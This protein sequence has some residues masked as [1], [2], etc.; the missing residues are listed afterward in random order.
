MRE[1]YRDGGAAGGGIIRRRRGLFAKGVPALKDIEDDRGALAS[2]CC[3]RVCRGTCATL[4]VALYDAY[5]RRARR[6]RVTC[7]GSAMEK[8]LYVSQESS[9][10]VELCY[11]ER[12]RVARRRLHRS[13]C[14]ERAI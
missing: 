3:S 5:D 14:D 2:C 1:E 7:R 11:A 9:S 6:A 10:V 4:L 8:E 13:R 12:C